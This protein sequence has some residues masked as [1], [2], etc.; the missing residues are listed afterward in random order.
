M[1]DEFHEKIKAMVKEL[2]QQDYLLIKEDAIKMAG[3]SN[4]TFMK[5]IENGISIAAGEKKNNCD[6]PGIGD[7]YNAFEKMPAK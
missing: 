3:I 4:V 5:G 7:A 2:L 6:I 1:Q